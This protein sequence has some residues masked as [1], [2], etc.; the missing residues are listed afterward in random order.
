MIENG[1]NLENLMNSQ[2]L[3]EK[4]HCYKIIQFSKECKKFEKNLKHFI[5]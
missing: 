4:V 2:N 3:S 5:R 1:N